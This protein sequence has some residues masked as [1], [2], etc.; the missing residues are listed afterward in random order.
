MF[1][2]A[3]SPRVLVVSENPETI[4][5]L[6]TYFVGVGITTQSARTLEATTSLPEQTTA[7][8]FFPDGFAAQDVIV[9][10]RALHNKRPRLLLLLVTREPRR[11]SSAL[12]TDGEQAALVVLA[13]PAFGWTIVDAI[14]IH[15]QTAAPMR[16]Q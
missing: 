15:A 16:A 7:V 3:P 9:R 13:K 2:A 14:R 8:V 12:T 6:Q 5:G 10:V 1:H 4:D 11:F